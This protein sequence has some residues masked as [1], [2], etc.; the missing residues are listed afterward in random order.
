[1]TFCNGKFSVLNDFRYAEFFA[2]YTL[3]SKSRRGSPRCCKNKQN[4]V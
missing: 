2:Y 1:M 4:N 3:E